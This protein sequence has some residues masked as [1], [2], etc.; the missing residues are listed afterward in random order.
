MRWTL[1]EYQ[2]GEIINNWRHMQ[3]HVPGSDVDFA[4]LIHITEISYNV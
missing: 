3:Q 2:E 4:E 1:Q